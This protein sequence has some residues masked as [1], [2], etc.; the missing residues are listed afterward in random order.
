MSG[1]KAIISKDDSPR[2]KTMPL[3]LVEE[4][5]AGFL[6]QKDMFLTI[7]VF[8]GVHRGHQ[9]LIAR[10]SEAAELANCQSGVITFKQHPQ[11]ILHPAARPPYLTNLEEKT[12]LLRDLRV[13]TV[14]GLSFT[15]ELARLS[16][17]EFIRLLI[18][19]LRLKTL[20]LGSD[21][22]LGHRREGNIEALARL[23][24][25][26]GFSVTVI[27]PLT[28]NGEVVSSTAIREALARSNMA[29]VALLIGRY[30]SLSRTVV[31]GSGRGRGLGFPTANLEVEPEQALPADGV[32]ATWVHFGGAARKAMTYVGRR[33][34][35]GNGQRNL[36]IFITDFSGDL[37]GQKIRVDFVAQVR[38]EM[39]FADVTALKR[40]IEADIIKGEAVLNASSR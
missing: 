2:N 34:T 10:L 37:Y 14:L 29:R 35:F 40:Q 8:D 7:G 12:A 33:P 6:P 3:S 4:E 38:G 25:E 1:W 13:D 30:F 27:P 19:K 32:Y 22:A 9:H 20:V 21:F 26:M 11:Y 28:I 17:R 36:E 39:C 24:R 23:G 5:L 31:H 16:S 18:I 15:P